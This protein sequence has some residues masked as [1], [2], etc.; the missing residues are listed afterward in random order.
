MRRT[1]ARFGIESPNLEH[2][3]W[4][5]LLRATREGRPVIVTVLPEDWDC[6][7]W[8]VIRG[9][10]DHPRR[11]WL[12]NYAEVKDGC[13]S[14]REFRNMWSPHGEGMVCQRG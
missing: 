7:H 9:M 4:A 11:V 5:K 12:S 10:K 3:G 1:L 6:D 8:V 13:L 2:L 14:W